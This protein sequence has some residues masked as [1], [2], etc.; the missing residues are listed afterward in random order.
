MLAERGEVVRALRSRGDHD[1]ALQAE[2]CLPK[3]VDLEE[4]KGLLQQMDVE[5]SDIRS[6]QG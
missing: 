4:D 1:R 3:M 6:P 2:C 5:V